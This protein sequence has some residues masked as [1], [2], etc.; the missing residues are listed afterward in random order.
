MTKLEKTDINILVV[1]DEEVVLSLVR[2]AL[3]DDG[4]RVATAP[5][6]L[7]ALEIIEHD[8][9]DLIVS[10]I[11][12][13]QMSGLELVEQVRKT[14][15][16]VEVIFTT[17]YAN[18]NSA[19]GALRQG[20]SDYILKPFELKEIRQA[21]SKAC[22]KIRSETDASESDKQLNRLSDLHQ[23]LFTV[24]D[25]KTLVTVSL[26]FAMMHC[27]STA[28][29]VVHWNSNTADVNLVS[30][31]EDE[32][33][34]RT[35]PEHVWLECL[36]STKLAA[37]PEPALVS[38]LRD[39]ALFRD[40]NDS[41]LDREIASCPGNHYQTK[42]VVPVSR[43]STVFGF[44]MVGVDRNSPR[45]DEAGLRFLNFT[46]HQLAMSLENLELLEEAQ[47]AYTRLKELQ[48]ETIQLEK[49]ATRG[50]MSA[51][52][53]HELNNFLGVVAGNLS[54]LDHNLKR[55]NY[56][57]L[58]KFVLA[59][60]DNIEKIKK[61]TSNLMDLRPISSRKE[62]VH[63]DR[64]I[65]E[66]ID[67]L[68][69]Q[70]RFQEVDIRL[71]PISHP[72][73]FE[74]DTIHIQQV[75]YK[76]FNNAADAM[77]DCDRRDIEVSARINEDRETFCVTIS[78]TGVG[79]PSDLLPKVF[80]EKFTTKEKGHGFGLLVSRRIIESHNGQLTIDS[81]GDRGTTVAITLPL[82]QP[83]REIPA[84]AGQAADAPATA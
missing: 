65:A 19:K 3:E 67:Y 14:H 59:M 76:L 9:I 49:M 6:A 57:E 62:V 56:S 12:M 53:G 38:S 78:D 60:A 72:L 33:T 48:D 68:K 71:A 74:A 13:P 58:E 83:T 36:S 25:R 73:P 5:D 8:H 61:F 7:K 10:D 39:H 52:I 17:G 24:G 51:E 84:P 54:L 26:R 37:P 16:K 31:S 45:L 15:P 29:V 75:L 11:R 35:L 80:N 34:E 79:I 42:I 2:D 47:N 66:V 43:G 4:F 28:G 50:E 81:T 18:L 21:V 70:R 32:V 44:L 27:D 1:D 20:A 22:D 46:A 40:G 69:P 82:K 55:Q 63:F 23:T 30:I 64:L 41:E 77:V